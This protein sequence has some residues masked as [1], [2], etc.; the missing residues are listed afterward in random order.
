[1]YI[2]KSVYII[3]GIN[4]NGFKE[5]LGFWIAESESAKQWLNIFNKLKTRG[6]Q[7]ILLAC[8]DNLKGISE[9]FKVAFQMYAF[10]SV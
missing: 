9:S 2:E 6:V 10:K 7:E 5:I 8:C 4:I 1:M 3:I